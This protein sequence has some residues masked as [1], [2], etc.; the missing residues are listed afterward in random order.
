MGKGYRN[1]DERDDAV[2]TKTQK[3]KKQKKGRQPLPKWVVPTI[4]T[5]VAVVVVFAIVF[6]ALVNNGV[7]KRNNVLVKSQQQ[8]KYSVN[9]MAAQIMLWYS[10][11]VQGQNAYYGSLSDLVSYS[12]YDQNTEFSW[13]WAYATSTQTDLQE[14]IR[15]SAEWLEELTALCDWGQKN[16]ISFTSEDEENAYSSFVSAFRS[17]AKSY[18]K[19]ANEV[20]FPNAD[21]ETEKYPNYS[22]YVDFPEYPYFSGFLKNIFGTG[23]KSADFRRA[24]TILTYAGR[25]KSIKTGEYWGADAETVAEEIKKNPDKYYT[26][27]YLRY[28]ADNEALAFDL[29]G[30]VGGEDGVNEFKKIIVTDYIKNNYYGEYNKALANKILDAL[31]D[32]SGKT[33]EVELET[34]N[35]PV[36]ELTAPVAEPEAAEGEE[37]PAVGEGE[38]EG[39]E[40]AATEDD[41]GEGEEPA[42]EEPAGEEPAGE[43]PVG[44]EA[45]AAELTEKQS[46]WLFNSARVADDMTIISEEDGSAALLVITEVTKDDAGKITS[47]KAAIKTFAEDLT[48][49]ELE[50]LI[51]EVCHELGLPH[52]HDH[53]AEEAEEPAANEE[54]QE[55]AEPTDSEEAGETED[56]EAAEGEESEE[57]TT[58]WD[59]LVETMTTGAKSKLPSTNKASYVKAADVDKDLEETKTELEAKETAEDKISY[60]KG[61]NASEYTNATADNEKIDDAVKAVVFPEEGTVEAG[62]IQI[63]TIDENT[64]HLIYVSEVKTEGEGEAAKTQVTFCDYSASEYPTKFQQFLFEEVDEETMTGGR[65]VGRTFYQKNSDTEH[66]VY[67]V[68]RALSL[69]DEVV[70]GGYISYSDKESADNDL[71]KL[72]GLTGAELINKLSLI[73]S[74]ATT[75]NAITQSS[76]SST[77]L[78]EWLFSESRQANDAAVVYHEDEDGNIMEGIY[79]A[80]F[81]DRTSAGESDARTNISQEKADDFAKGIAES[82]NYKLSERALGKVGSF[83]YR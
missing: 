48:E 75:S 20:G 47:V 61:K 59:K 18:Y 50:T 51:N 19:Y 17:Q 3:P 21:G 60:L 15:S 73:N 42:G 37:A 13:C 9:Q 52:D 74:S 10:G 67:I 38:G 58:A 27:D 12:D 1:R 76:V 62:L 46:E 68:T 43:E 63:I 16:G 41:E 34:Q 6:A 33:L 14:T 32:K 64:K 40:P 49:E 66:I 30:V 71:K 11:W 24:A 44:E 26:L 8:S 78:K 53:E 2:L 57:E 28:T 23:I 4:V 7:F 22:S 45:P 70:R 72:E 79:L 82:G 31:K 54:D 56:G 25:V 80:V 81:L 35:I 39:E 77:D 5:I 69:G 36:V 83:L 55:G 29:I 65:E